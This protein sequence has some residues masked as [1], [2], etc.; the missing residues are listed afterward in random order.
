[1]ESLS[2]PDPPSSAYGA[3]GKRLSPA[4]RQLAGP[5]SGLERLPG[6]P[7]GEAAWQGRWG[8]LASE[9]QEFRNYTLCFRL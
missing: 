1:M 8:R 9:H 7:P 5:W 2:P 6:A 4:F 3:L